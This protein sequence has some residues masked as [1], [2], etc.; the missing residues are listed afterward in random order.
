MSSQLVVV[1][2]GLDHKTVSS[3]I[4]KTFFGNFS[5]SPLSSDL[6]IPRFT[7]EQLVPFLP[8]SPFVLP[9]LILTVNILQ[10]ICLKSKPN[11]P[12]AEYPHM[13]CEIHG[14]PC[15]MGNEAICKIVS[16]DECE[17]YEGRFHENLTLC[18]QVS[19]STEM[20]KVENFYI[21]YRGRFH[22]RVD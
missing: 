5:L 9:T 6:S 8:C 19:D 12:F 4:K 1:R 13:T 21:W 18:S 14:R 7:R 20:Y 10:Q 15:C 17:F 2:S 22:F 16:R 3:F 11:L